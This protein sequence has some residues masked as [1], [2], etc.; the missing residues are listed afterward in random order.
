M[1]YLTLF[2]FS[3]ENWRR[4]AGE[5]GDLMDLLRLYLRREMAELCRNGVRLR[6]IGDRAGLPADIVTLI[7]EAED[8][9][10]RQ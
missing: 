5:V 6:V 10:P 1:R 7:E 3:S 4:P 2:A 9:Q 8:A